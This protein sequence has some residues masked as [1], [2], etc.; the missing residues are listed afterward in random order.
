M[1]ILCKIIA[2]KSLGVFC[3]LCSYTF[4]SWGYYQ[5]GFRSNSTQHWSKWFLYC[6]PDV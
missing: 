4:V 1:L 3:A 6:F 2:T 5:Y